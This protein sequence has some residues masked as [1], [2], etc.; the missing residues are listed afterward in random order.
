ML[1]NPGLGTHVGKGAVAIVVKKPAWTWFEDFRNAVV[2]TARRIESAAGIFVE[3]SKLTDEEIE[4]P[5]VI[6][7]EPDR[8]RGPAP[9]RYARF[10]GDVSK[11]S[12]AVVAIENIAPPLR[13]VNVWKAIVVVVAPSYSPSIAAAGHTSLIGHVGKGSV[14]VIAIQRIE[15]RRLRRIKIRLAAVDQVNVQPAVVVV[16]EKGAPGSACLGQMLFGGFCRGVDPSNAAL[17]WQNLLERR[18]R[19]RVRGQQRKPA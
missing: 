16:I 10:F 17:R 2:M 12:I 11:C 3:L 7:I 4:S 13:D 18:A 6:V 9:T 1:P 19:Q 8:A 15:K 5:I 14:T